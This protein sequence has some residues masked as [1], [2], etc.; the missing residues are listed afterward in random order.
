MKQENGFG[1]A[2]NIKRLWQVLEV[3]GYENAITAAAQLTKDEQ[4]QFTENDINLWGYSLINQNKLNEALA[5][6]KLNTHLYPHS[7]NTF[8]SLAEAYWYLGDLKQATANYN[9]VLK[10]KPDNAHAKKQLAKLAKLM[11]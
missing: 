3:Q 4:V 6:F 5:I 9:H 11:E 8:D 2:K 10:L 7:Y 1:L